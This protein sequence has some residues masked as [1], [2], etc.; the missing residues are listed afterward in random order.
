MAGVVSTNSVETPQ[1]AVFDPY[2]ELEVM[3]EKAET[4]AHAWGQTREILYGDVWTDR[5]QCRCGAVRL[6]YPWCGK[7]SDEI[8]LPAKTS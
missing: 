2:K 7:T 6:V 3:M 8:R 1:T 5:S 4:H